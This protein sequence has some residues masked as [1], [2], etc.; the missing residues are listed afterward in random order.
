MIILGH[1]EPLTIT[2]PRD[3][4]GRATTALYSDLSSTDRALRRFPDRVLDTPRQAALA[5]ALRAAA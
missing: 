3:I 5:E 4:L 1:N 2:V